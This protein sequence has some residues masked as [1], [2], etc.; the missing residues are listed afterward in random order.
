M[1]LGALFGKSED[2]PVMPK[3]HDAEAKAAE[4]RAK[5]LRR[6]G[7]MSTVLNRGQQTRPAGAGVGGTVG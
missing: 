3:P 4:Q 5:L 6:S 1:S 7:F 2:P